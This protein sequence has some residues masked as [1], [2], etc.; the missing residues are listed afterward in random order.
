ML[1]SL[2]NIEYIKKNVTLAVREICTII[3]PAKLL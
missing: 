1:E 3:P 2:N